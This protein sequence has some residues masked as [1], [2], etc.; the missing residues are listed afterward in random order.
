MANLRRLIGLML[1]SATLGW[2]VLGDVFL[3]QF[4]GYDHGL[5]LAEAE[6]CGFA[7]AVVGAFTGLSIDLM[8]RAFNNRTRR[9]SVRD[10]IIFVTLF[11]FALGT[12]VIVIQ[13]ARSTYP[14]WYVGF[15]PD[16]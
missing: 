2:I 1:L 11:A 6:R 13:F 8:M 14:P 9:Y 3:S 7:G 5:G 4:H 16:P 15:R 10:L 12:S